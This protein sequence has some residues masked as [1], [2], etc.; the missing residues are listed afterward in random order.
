[1]PIEINQLHIKVNVKGE[2]RQS[3]APSPAGNKKGKE[4]IIAT[5]VESVLEI[6]EREKLR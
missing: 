1:M 2:E 4:A 3:E 5:C 6:L